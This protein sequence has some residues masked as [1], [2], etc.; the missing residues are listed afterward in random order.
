MLFHEIFHDQLNNDDNHN[1]PSCQ[2][3]FEEINRWLTFIDNKKELNRFLPRLKA[4][5]LQRNIAFTE[6]YS[7][8][9]LET[10]LNYKI[11]SFEEKT[12]GNKNVDLI[13]KDGNQKIYCEVKCPCWG[14]ELNKQ[15]YEERIKKSKYINGECTDCVKSSHELFQNCCSS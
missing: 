14:G 4:Q 11:I 3:W 7:A 15:E 2:E 8:Y 5:K 6:I 1:W 10:I 12:I 9:V 13:F